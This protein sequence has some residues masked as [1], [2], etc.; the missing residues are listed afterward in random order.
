[1]AKAMARAPQVDVRKGRT[2]LA[3]LGL[4]GTA[5]LLQAVAFVLASPRGSPQVLTARSAAE[6]SSDV[7]GVLPTR[8]KDLR[9]GQEMEDEMLCSQRNI[10]HMMI[11]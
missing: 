8:M 6:E 2:T 9:V 4:A 10:K 3:L 11:G 7:V 5:W 1:M